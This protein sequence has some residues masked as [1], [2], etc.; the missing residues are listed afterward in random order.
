MILLM[1]LE[2]QQI[3]TSII[4]MNKYLRENMNI[5]MKEIK[6]IENPQKKF[7]VKNLQYMK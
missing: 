2:D 4:I 7:Q 1:K 3:K 5:M 6:D